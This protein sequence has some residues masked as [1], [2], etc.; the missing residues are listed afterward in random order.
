MEHDRIPR[1][2]PR[3][4]EFLEIG[5]MHSEPKNE[6]VVT[7]TEPGQTFCTEKVCVPFDSTRRSSGDAG[8]LAETGMLPLVSRVGCAEES[9]RRRWSP[10]KATR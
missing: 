1:F 3:V 5:F 10:V 8:G 9:Q 6:L 4:L 7:A 2:G